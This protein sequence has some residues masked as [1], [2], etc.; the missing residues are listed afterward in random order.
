MT[1]RHRA[2]VGIGSNIDR[3][4]NIQGGLARL[5]EE[6]GKLIVSAVYESRSYG[7]SGDNF[8]NLVAGFD[9][10][11][12]VSSVAERLRE[13]EYEFGRQRSQEKF[14]SRTL[15]IDLL[16]Y[17][18]LV[19]NDENLVLPREDVLK[20]S[21]VLCPLADIAAAELHPVTGTSYAKHWEEYTGTREDIW[22]SGFD[23]LAVQPH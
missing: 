8:Y 6:F 20:Y 10:D 23:P 2:Y 9:T 3:E 12:P 5:R 7:F 21:F 11:L 14:S 13:I 22:K 18:D 17:G 19:C 1:E 16:L 4:D 15:D